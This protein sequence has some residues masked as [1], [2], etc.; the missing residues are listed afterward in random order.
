MRKKNQQGRAEN[1]THAKDNKLVAQA[2]RP[3]RLEKFCTPFLP[4]FKKPQ[5]SYLIRTIMNMPFQYWKKLLYP[6]VA[7]IVI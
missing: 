3:G 1:V 6:C 4:H 2:R 7:V 5:L